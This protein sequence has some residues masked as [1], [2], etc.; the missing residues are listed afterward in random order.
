[1]PT[2]PTN[3]IMDHI[4]VVEDEPVLLE[5]IKLTMEKMGGF[6][7]TAV[8]NAENALEKIGNRKY[9][10]IISDYDMPGMNGLEFLETVRASGDDTP[11][12]IF[13]GKGREEIAIKAYELGADHYIQKGG[14]TRSL[15]YEIIQKINTAV[16][17]KQISRELERSRKQYTNIFNHLP[18][19]TFV[20]DRDGKVIGWN[21]AI[22]K[23]TGVISGEI[24]GKGD[25]AYSEALYGEK[26]PILV[27]LILDPCLSI[28]DDY[29]IIHCD[30]GY[31]TAE[32]NLVFPDGR[33]YVI[34]VKVSP[35]TGSDSRLAGAIASIRDVTKKRNAE[36]QIRLANEYN[37]CLIEAHIDP[38]VTIDDKGII[39]D[40][41]TAMEKLTGYGRDTLEG[42]CFFN[43]FT[44]PEKARE[45]HIKVMSGSHVRELHL[46]VRIAGGGESQVLFFG[47][48]YVGE[49]GGVKGVFAELHD[50]LTFPVG[51]H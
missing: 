4:L 13:T 18:D 37:R 39:I 6:E 3:H 26:R 50:F 28:R 40:I 21:T 16:E 32:K 8:L 11:F 9:S 22:E 49:K 44:S 10:A 41:N 42:T 12:I 25:Y 33:K 38:L 46:S 27:D 20:I 14:D 34:W 15:F 2:Y 24:I 30:D 43:L 29:R 47:S 5:V 35:L 51:D 23:L 19:P 45:G 7:V 17:K 31:F 48:P 1:M 36:E